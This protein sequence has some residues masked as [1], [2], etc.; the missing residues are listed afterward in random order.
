MALAVLC[1][2]GL[3][4]SQ[5]NCGSDLATLKVGMEIDYPPFEYTVSPA[6]VTGFDV[7]VA[8]ALRDK[9]GYSA[10]EI[11]NVLRQDQSAALLVGT[12][13]LA[14]SAQSIPL[15]FDP[16]TSPIAYVKYNDDSSSILWFDTSP[17]PVTS[18]NALA[19]LNSLPNDQIP[20]LGVLRGTREAEILDPAGPFPNLAANATFYQTYEDAILDF[21]DEALDGLLL[22]GAV[23]NFAFNEA[24]GELLPNVSAPPAVGTQG[25]GIVMASGCC[26]LY[27]NVQQAIAEL[28]ADGT[29]P[30]LREEF[31][32]GTLGSSLTPPGC[33]NT[34]GVTVNRNDLAQFI[35]DKY[36]PCEP[37][38]V[39]SP[40]PAATR[41]KLPSKT[42]L[43]MAALALSKKGRSPVVQNSKTESSVKDATHGVSTSGTK[44]VV[45][46]SQ[47]L[48]A[49]TSKAGV[50]TEKDV[51]AAREKSARAEAERQKEQKKAAT[52]KKS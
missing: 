16:A 23:A 15:V 41:L 17:V 30:A 43:A 22:Q 10:L 9:L 34:V 44:K 45:V 36:C 1:C 46:P 33:A 20:F 35:F 38:F 8:C 49:T 47:V 7:A 4:A 27:A 6:Q 21:E 29:L 19:V 12:I 18:Q 25:L 5:P 42:D 40:L 2:E 37:V 28:E 50:M 26:Q 51:I 39:G 13:S 32:T 11:T 24:G 14:I 31:Q 3:S 52:V 48:A